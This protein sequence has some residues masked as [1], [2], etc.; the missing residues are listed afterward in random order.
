M[1]RRSAKGRKP[2]K[3]SPRSKTKPKHGNAAKAARNRRLSAPRKDTEVAR[4]VRERDEALERET[5]TS[6]ILRLVS[7][8]PGNLELVFRS[9]LEN[10]T[11]ICGAKFGTLYLREADGVRVVAMHDAP[12]AFLEECRRNPL[13]HPEGSTALGRAMATKESVQIADVRDEAADDTLPSG[14]TAAQVATLAG[15]RAV[16]NVPMVKEDELIGA[17]VIYRQEVKPFT[18]SADRACE[19][20][21]GSGGHRYRELAAAQ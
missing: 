16:L 19:Q 18:H 1:I 13:I 5:A 21:R 14:H 17:V 10:A 7:R 12:S 4:L 11:R 20:L 9:I 3:T 6:E 15:A 2:A 8:S